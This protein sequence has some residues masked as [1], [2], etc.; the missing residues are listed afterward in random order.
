MEYPHGFPEHLKP[1]VE[2]AMARAEIKYLKACSEFD[3]THRYETILPTSIYDFVEKIF[4]VF[5]KQAREA[6]REGLWSIEQIRL[7]TEDYLHHLIVD[8]FFAKDPSPT[9]FGLKWFE[10]EARSHLFASKDWMRHQRGLATLAR[11]VSVKKQPRSL[12]Q[13]SSVLE[14]RQRF[15]K[16]ILDEKGWSILDWANEAEVAYHTAADYFAGKKNPFRSTRAKLAK[17]LG[18]PVNSFPQ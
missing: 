16:P 3:P 2:Q 9:T 12:G 8:A 1:P 18:T 6:G 15:V 5:T 17:A 11:S 14:T 13:T 7:A 4:F 10:S